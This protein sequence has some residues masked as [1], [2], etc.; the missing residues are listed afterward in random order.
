MQNNI[1]MC[2]IYLILSV[3]ITR[4]AKGALYNYINFKFTYVLFSSC[5]QYS[6]EFQQQNFLILVATTYIREQ[7]ANSLRTTL[8]KVCVFKFVKLDAY[9]ITLSQNPVAI[10]EK[11]LFK[12]ISKCILQSEATSILLKCIEWYSYILAGGQC[13]LCNHNQ[14]LMQQYT[15]QY[16]AMLYFTVLSQCCEDVSFLIQSIYIQRVKHG[17]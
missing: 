4:L 14:K 11:L 12:A 3:T 10:I 8:M 15:L 17:N 13:K 16:K 5:L 2:Y 9:I 6:F 1:V 7:F